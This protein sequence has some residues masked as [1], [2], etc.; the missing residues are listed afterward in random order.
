MS[1]QHV[2]A[3]L[4]TA[5]YYFVIET[6]GT[7]LQTINTLQTDLISYGSEVTLGLSYDAAA[8]TVNYALNGKGIVNT[9]TNLNAFTNGVTVTTSGLGATMTDTP[10]SIGADKYN[11]FLAK[12]ATYSSSLSNSDLLKYVE[13]PANLPTKDRVIYLDATQLASVAQVDNS[14]V[15]V[16]KLTFGPAA[17]SG[18]ITIDGLGTG[19][20]SLSGANGAK[21]VVQAGDSGNVIAEKVRVALTDNLRFKPQLEKQ[22]I[23]FGTNTAGTTFKVA[24]VSVT[25]LAADTGIA[26]A[27]K[28]KAALEASTFITDTTKYGRSIQDNGDGSLLITF[29]AADGDAKPI[30]IDSLLTT[31]AA[32]VDTVQTYNATGI[33]RSVTRDG[34]SVLIGMNRADQ[35]AKDLFVSVGAT[36]ITVTTPNLAVAPQTNEFTSYIP[37]TFTFAG[38]PVGEIQR[39]IVT[40]PAAA[41]GEVITFAGVIASTTVTFVAGTYSTAQTATKIATDLKAAVTAGT[42]TNVLDVVA[43]G[44]HVNIQFMPGS[45]NVGMVT[46]ASVPTVPAATTSS[47]IFTVPQR[48]AQ[49][50]TGEAQ[51]IT[52]TKATAGGSI[53]VDGIPVAVALND[54]PSAIATKVQKAMLDSGTNVSA[55]KYATPEIQTLTFLS[56]ASAIG[57]FSIDVPA[58]NATAATTATVTTV[59]GSETPAQ[60]AAIA[61]AALNGVAGAKYFA[62][63]DGDSVKVTFKNIARD[64]AMLSNVS[65]TAATIGVTATPF[66]TSQEFNAN[67]LRTT[68]INT[69]G[70]LTI[71][72]GSDEGTLGDVTPVLFTDTG[73]TAVTASVATT[74]LAHTAPVSSSSYT[75]GNVNTNASSVA[76]NVL[77]TQ[78]VSSDAPVGDKKQLVFDIYVNSVATAQSQVG[79]GFESVGF[80]LNYPTGDVT[81]SKVRIDMASSSSTPVTNLNTAG[82]IVARWVNTSSVTDF[83]KP[84]ARVTIEQVGQAGSFKDALDLSFTSVDIDGVDFTNGSAFTRSFADTLVTDRWDVKQ[85]LVN[86]LDGTTPIGGQLVG[87]YGNPTVNASQISLKYSALTDKATTATAPSLT[88]PDKTL[89][90]NVVSDVASVKSAKFAIDLPSNANNFNFT[91]S[92]EAIAAGM[93]LTPASSTVLQGAKG[94]TFY[95]ELSGGTGTGLATGTSIGKLSVDLIGGKDITHKFSF[96]GTPTLNGSAATPQGLY[97]GYT[98]TETLALNAVTGLSKGEWIARDMP[99]G[100]FNKFFVATAPTDAAKVIT[101][102]DALQILKLSA[103]YSLDWKSGD[104]PVGA[105]AAAD[106]DGSGKVTAADALIALKYATGTIPSPDP[107]AWKFYDST[108]ANLGVDNTVI[109]SSLKADMAIAGGSNVDITGQSD[110]FVQAILVGNVT[111]PALEG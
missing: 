61:A 35:D 26:I 106:L 29:S 22:L 18:V 51:T 9:P 103:G 88:N 36:G 50:L 109:N 80:T 47:G 56:G 90:M 72:F 55:G 2:D 71:E 42:I 81:S 37:S 60:V 59:T 57:S 49:N 48:F 98:S 70:S 44:D 62:I 41:S 63:A 78:L 94:H 43:D 64:A 12:L 100:T 53:T 108:T 52:F 66:S 68:R 82:Q 7:T 107:V 96:A 69:D 97:A 86:G 11:G 13:D 105:Y 45:G 46:A 91:L 34:S 101:A 4:S 83:S 32:S 25:I 95:V 67:G 23:T 28:V 102:A 19:L 30:A 92:T 5:G 89:V 1:I 111:N 110:F 20:S 8:G 16:Q 73:T 93:S 58:T 39:Y 65:S 31:V 77:Y 40:T 33:G 76:S 6:L 104:V 87:Y 79:S 3:G 27:T 24:G 15:E 54:A 10:L 38:T 21:I 17:A 14:V 74:R 84:I 99:K 85:K 75:G